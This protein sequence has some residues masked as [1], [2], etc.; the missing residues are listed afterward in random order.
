MAEIT[1]A[2]MIRLVKKGF[3]TA[4]IITAVTIITLVMGGSGLNH[5]EKFTD[6]YHWIAKTKPFWLV[7]RLGLYLML[8]WGGW[9]IW[10]VTKTKP[11]YRAALLR[12][13]MVSLLFILLCEY[14]LS[15]H[16]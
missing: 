1:K 7:W 5:A 4:L 12:M 9:K 13:M 16:Y 14:A 3:R 8:G 15:G 10:Q 2:Q 11:E 6:L